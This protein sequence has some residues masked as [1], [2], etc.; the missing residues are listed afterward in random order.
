MRRSLGAAC[1]A[2]LATIVVVLA[3]PAGATIYKCVQAGKTAYQSWPCAAS[4]A[5][6]TMPSSTPARIAA[7]PAANAP[8]PSSRPGPWP[9]RTLT[10]G[11]P[12]DAVLNLAGW[13]RPDRITRTRRPREWREE[14]IYGEGTAAER[15]LVFVNARLIG[16]DTPPATSL[17]GLAARND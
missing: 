6:T 11:M 12:D 5:E 8:A 4:A 17:A 7:A 1:R 2:L 3:L 9:Q 15:R 14:W 10:L 13:G 16:I